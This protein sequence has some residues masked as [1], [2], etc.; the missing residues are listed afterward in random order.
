M[1]GYLLDTNA[2][3]MFAPSKANVSPN[4]AN[5]VEEQEKLDAIYLS[6]LMVHEI[7]RGIRLLEAKGATSKA[8]IIAMFLQ[9][10][11]AGYGDRILPIDAETA[12]E[13]GRLEAKAAAAGHNPGTVDALIAGTASIRGLIV[14]THNLKHFRPF[15][16]PARSPD[17]LAIGR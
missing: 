11:I 8:S 7:E 12:R 1:T 9:G 15:G 16:I 14:I 17:E 3:S 6:A 2:V 13:S 5:W 10:M 4:F